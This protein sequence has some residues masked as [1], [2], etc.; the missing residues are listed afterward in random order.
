MYFDRYFG[1][2]AMLCRHFVLFFF[3]KCHVIKISKMFGDFVDDFVSLCQGLLPTSRHLEN[4]RGEGP[5][6]EVG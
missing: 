4:R 3:F 1:S 2:H 6:D 5:G